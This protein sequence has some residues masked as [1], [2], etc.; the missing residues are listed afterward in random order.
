M[1]HVEHKLESVDINYSE[2]DSDE[3]QQVP[4]LPH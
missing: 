3:D 2:E 4:N 1:E